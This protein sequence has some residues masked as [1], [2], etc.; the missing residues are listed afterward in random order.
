LRQ[1]SGISHEREIFLAHPRQGVSVSA[2]ENTRLV[3]SAYEAFG[4]GDIA[5][6]AEM[7]A[8][9][10][11]VGGSRR[12]R[13]RPERRNV[14]RQG[15][16]PRLV[17][18]SCIDSRLHDVRATRVHR[19]ERQGVS[20]VYAEATVRDTGRAFV[21]HEAHV[22]TFRDGSSP[23]SRAITT[24][25]RRLLPTAWRNPPRGTGGSYVAWASLR[26]VT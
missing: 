18:G 10:H 7:M 19:P 8:D 16:S 12:S 17:R 24:P 15:S 1:C 3:H 9:R 5:A 25:Q 20:L 26:N 14:Q 11:R 21:S 13:R 2:E 6:L 22:W 4:R 23:D